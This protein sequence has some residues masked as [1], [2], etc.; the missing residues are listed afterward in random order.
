MNKQEAIERIK[1][2]YSFIMEDG[3]FEVGLINK[4]QVLDIISKI[5]EQQKVA[6][7]KFVAEWIEKHKEDGSRLSHALEDVF[8]DA[9]LS[10]YIKQQEDDY[11]EVI[12]EAWIAY[13]NI[14]VEQ[15]RLYTV[16]IPD[17]HGPYKI[18]YL[19]RNSMGNICIGGTDYRGIFLDVDTRL[20]ESEIKK[21]F[22][23]AW[24][25]AKEVEEWVGQY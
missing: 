12:A 24:Q 13:P 8:D 10:L 22:E 11:T 14:A 17:P 3:P 21:D 20:T 2:L 5:D 4:N 15:E 19:F 23:W 6:V 7:P 9:E 18:R 25:W 1:N 16:E